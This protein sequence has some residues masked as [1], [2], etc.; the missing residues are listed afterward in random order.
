MKRSTVLTSPTSLLDFVA[1]LIFFALAPWGIILVALLFPV[2]GTLVSIT[3][4]L[5]VLAVAETAQRW[6]N[7]SW[8]IR[9]LIKR[10]LEMDEFYHRHPPRP[11]A[12]YLFYPL[13]FPYWLF[14]NREARREFWFFK[15][16]TATGVV[17]LMGSA[18]VQYFRFWPP[19][20]G[21]RSFVPTLAISL[22]V[23]TFLVL[24]LLM[25]LATT[26]IG[27]HQTLRRGRLI[28]LLLVGLVST[29]AGIARVMHRRSPIVSYATRNRVRLRSS[30]API[31][32]HAARLAAVQAAWRELHDHP[33]SVEGDGNV[34]GDPLEHAHDT[35]EAFYR[36]DEAYAFDL[37]ASPRRKPK[38]L[39]LYFEARR[40]HD[41]IWTA[42]RDGA[43]V[44][45]PKA[46]PKGA[47]AAMKQAAEQ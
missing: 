40:G 43:E 5:L 45:D 29:S 3:V 16:Y 33:G 35:L 26:V 28:I 9:M 36:H 1:R 27:F 15:G 7:R 37:W 2:T 10:E 46:L 32:A 4:A 8:I 14:L 11:F 47:F 42:F 41:P 31:R 12:Y 20:L 44:R 34:Q 30:A 25:P 22:V 21:L 18:V 17:I 6:A 24:W 19:E 23:E 38:V 39:V 13:L